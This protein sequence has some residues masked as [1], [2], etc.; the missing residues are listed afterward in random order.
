MDYCKGGTLLDLIKKSNKLS[1]SKAAFYFK[2]ILS[3]LYFLHSKNTV[4]R[5]LKLENILLES[6]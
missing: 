2:G 5:D 6:E 3:A 1:E 4:H